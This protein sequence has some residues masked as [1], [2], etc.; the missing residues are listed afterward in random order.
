MSRK[1]V[2]PVMD[3]GVPAISWMGVNFDR[4]AEVQEM[5]YPGEF[6]LRTF[7]KAR[8]SASDAI[9]VAALLW[10]EFRDYRDGVFLSSLFDQAGVD[11]WFEQYQSAV[12]AVEASCNHLHLWDAFSAQ[13]EQDRTALSAL[14]AVMQRTWSSALTSAYSDRRF[15]VRFSD[16][17]TEYGPT[18][19]FFSVDS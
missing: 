2:D 13:T 17:P 9:S 3:H 11:R 5:F 16:E 12:S 6:E 10:P 14:G 19:T 7:L 8:V 1:A 15:E 18:L 4:F